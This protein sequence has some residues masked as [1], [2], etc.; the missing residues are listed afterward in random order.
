MFIIHIYTS[1]P[2]TKLTSAQVHHS[3]IY[4]VSNDQFMFT[5]ETYIYKVSNDHA[6]ISSLLDHKL[7]LF[8]FLSQIKKFK[9][10]CHLTF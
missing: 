7:L 1:S 2:F 6:A 8:S 5:H 10:F 3:H 4:K 9:I